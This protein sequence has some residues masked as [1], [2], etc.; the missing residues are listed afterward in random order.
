MVGLMK[1]KLTSYS[2]YTLSWSECFRPVFLTE[3]SYLFQIPSGHGLCCTGYRAVDTLYHTGS[4]A[5]RIGT[6]AI[7]PIAKHDRF[8]RMNE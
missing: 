4:K 7:F 1:M 2:A 3:R 6:V 5:P 8:D